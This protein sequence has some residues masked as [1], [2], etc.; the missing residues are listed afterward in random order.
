FLAGFLAVLA[1]EPV[2]AEQLGK[3]LGFFEDY[4]NLLGG[5]RLDEVIERAVAHAF[6]GRFHGTETRADNDQRLLR[7]QLDGFQQF[8]AI[9]VRQPDIE[10][11]EVKVVLVEVFLGVGDGGNGSNIVTA[12]AELVFEIFADDQIV[13]EDDDFLDRHSQGEWRRYNLA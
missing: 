4:F 6:D 5:V 3:F 9:A 2:D 10:K 12:L 11:N 13:F 7:T 1:E 8:G